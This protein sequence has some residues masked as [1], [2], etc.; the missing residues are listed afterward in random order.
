MS[1]YVLEHDKEA[2]RLE[3]MSRISAYQPS[4]EVSHLP[5]APGKKVLD[6]GCGSGL[7][8]RYIANT[9]PGV[10][11][12]GCDQ[13]AVRME[14]AQQIRKGEGKQDIRFFVSH[15]EAIEAPDATYDLITCRYVFEFLQNPIQVLREFRRVLKPGGKALVI[16]FDGFLFN[17][18]HRNK[19]L[20]G[21][22]SEL[23]SK[24]GM[25]MFMGRKIPALMRD[26]GFSSV[27]WD[28]KVY[29][30]KG[31]EVAAEQEQ[32][33][34]RLD[35][36]LSALTQIFGSSE[37]AAYFRDL[38]CREMAGPESVLFYNKFLVTGTN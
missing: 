13:S 34:E 7:V 25:D 8:A 22:L 6:A 31:K 4:E 18:H 12:E 33:W 1:Q 28:V 3:K 14:Q 29:G 2:A 32:N 36:A 30:F 20:A 11:V 16:Q 17:Y 38:Y 35:F 5:F 27:D 37:K 26:A 10:I 21:M 19:E 24:L 9:Y 23:Q 15:L